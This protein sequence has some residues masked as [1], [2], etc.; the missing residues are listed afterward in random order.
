MQD[1]AHA[2]GTSAARQGGP[3]ED[4]LEQAS[5]RS[6]TRASLGRAPSSSRG[7]ASL[8]R[9]PPRS[10][11]RPPRA[12]SASLEG[13]P[14]P[15]PGSASLEGAPHACA[16]PRTWAFNALTPVGRRHHAPGLAPRCCR[17]NSPG[18][19]P[20]PS[21]WRGTVPVTP[22]TCSSTANAPSPRRRAG[23]TLDLLSCDPAGLSGGARPAGR[24]PCY[25]YGMA[26][27]PARAGA[28]QAL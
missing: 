22:C 9:A 24:H 7:C 20:S 8:E 28:C 19:S 26:A 5:P 2:A 4:P 3:L 6:R 10:R 15:R 23:C 11:A 13:P 27:A 14:R 17:T 1:A 21:L 25:C 16:C 12:G 18:G